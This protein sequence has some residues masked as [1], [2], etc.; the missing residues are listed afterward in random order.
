[1]ETGFIS[2]PTE[3]AKNIMNSRKWFKRLRKA[4]TK[5]EDIQK[6]LKKYCRIYNIEYVELDEPIIASMPNQV[7]CY[8]CRRVTEDDKKNIVSKGVVRC[9]VDNLKKGAFLLRKCSFHKPDLI[10][11]ALV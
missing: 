5:E 8:N 3:V 4:K 1:M 6:V 10:E 7:Q 11:R 2:V 9:R